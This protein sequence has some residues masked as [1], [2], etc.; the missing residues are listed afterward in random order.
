MP[1]ALVLVIAANAPLVYLLSPVR[2]L[3]KDQRWELARLSPNQFFFLATS[4]S[5]AALLTAYALTEVEPGMAIKVSLVGFL[6]G[7][8]LAISDDRGTFRGLAELAKLQERTNTIKKAL[9]IASASSIHTR[10]K[11][12]IV[13]KRTTKAPLFWAGWT[14]LSCK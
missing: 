6:V 7:T 4:F 3:T 14:R 2:G 13:S 5:P 8:F 12:A 9:Q 1:S 10:A 11:R